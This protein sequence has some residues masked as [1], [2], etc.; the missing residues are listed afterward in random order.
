MRVSLAHARLGRAW[1]ARQAA[2]VGRAGGDG[3]RLAYKVHEYKIG[4]ETLLFNAKN[5]YIIFKLFVR[6]QLPIY[7]NWYP[8]RVSGNLALL[9]EQAVGCLRGVSS[10]AAG[11]QPARVCG[12]ATATWPGRVQ[13]RPR[14]P[15][16]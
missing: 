16:L 14:S 10:V 15:P 4:I 2:T 12:R 9:L 7:V 3:G 11:P 13:A 5:I 1:G 6:R 8:P